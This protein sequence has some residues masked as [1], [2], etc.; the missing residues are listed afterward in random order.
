MRYRVLRPIDLGNGPIPA[1]EYVTDTGWALNRA[2][3]LVRMRVIELAE[4]PK[5]DPA[6]PQTRR[7]ATM[8][9]RAAMYATPAGGRD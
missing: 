7:Q 6:K 3:Q 2:A 4:T 9:S 1:G 5:A 8:D